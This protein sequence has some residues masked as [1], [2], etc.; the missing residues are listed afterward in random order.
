[1]YAFGKGETATTVSIQQDVIANGAS[2]LIKGTVTDQSSGAKDTPAIADEHMGPW[3]EYLYMQ[4]PMPTNATGVTV[5]LQAMRSDGTVI[6]ITHVTTDVMGHYEY[7]WTPPAEDTYKILA[8]FEQSESYY[9]SSAQTGLS[10]GP[11]APAPAAPEAAPDNTPMYFAISTI[12]IIAAIAIVGM[13][14]LRKR[15]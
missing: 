7:T 12:L 9:T 11:A 6:D 14:M 4:K 13:L 8:T 1:M 3:M 15:P 10:V 5:F 2:V